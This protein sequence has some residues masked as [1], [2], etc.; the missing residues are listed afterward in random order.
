[1]KIGVLAVQGAAREHIL[2]LR[3][4]GVEAVP[5]LRPPDLLDLSGIVLPGGES[6]AQ[7]RL[8][9]R[10][11]LA[12]PLKKALEE[13]LPAFGTCAG[14]IL[15]AKEITNWP[16]HYLGLLDVA[17]ERN[18]TGRQVD[19]FEA[20]VEVDGL[21]EVPAVFIRAPAIRRVGRGVEVLGTH[22][23][24]PALV[25]QGAIL[26]ATFHPELTEDLRVHELFLNLCR[27]E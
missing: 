7:W 19:S 21:G 17:V 25:K 11:G 27:K 9:S 4:L 3:K 5:V 16:E 10:A 12:E 1:M 2:C 23:D 18:A 22:D 24:E 8:L 6:T 20:E 14:L 15:L 13:G 26:G